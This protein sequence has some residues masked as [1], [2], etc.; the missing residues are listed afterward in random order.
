MTTARARQEWARVLD[1]A[2]RGTPVVITSHGQ[3]VAAVVSMEQF[4]R[5]DRPRRPLGEVI[6]AARAAIDVDDLD[7]PDPFTNLRDRSPGRRIK[8]G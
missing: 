6:R 4:A 7:G 8:L 2:R 1:S 3:A 5:L